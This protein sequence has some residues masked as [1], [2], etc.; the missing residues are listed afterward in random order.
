MCFGFGAGYDLLPFLVLCEIRWGKQNWNCCLHSFTPIIESFILPLHNV[1]KKFSLK[2][3]LRSWFDYN[4]IISDVR[5][6]VIKI[7][8]L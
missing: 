1:P 8:N 2:P 6:L 7:R 5:H 3:L 4:R